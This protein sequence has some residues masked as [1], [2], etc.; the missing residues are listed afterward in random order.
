MSCAYFT[1]EQ[2]ERLDSKHSEEFKKLKLELLKCVE[3]ISLENINREITLAG[4]EPII[5]KLERERL[6]LKT[7]RELKERQMIVDQLRQELIVPAVPK[8]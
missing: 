2:F 4:I 5:K 6:L 1:P 3:E 7:I 8:V